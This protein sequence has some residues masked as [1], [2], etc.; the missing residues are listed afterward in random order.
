MNN[1]IKKHFAFIKNDSVDGF[2]KP[3]L[4]PQGR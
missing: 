3:Q 2:L 4:N 1:F